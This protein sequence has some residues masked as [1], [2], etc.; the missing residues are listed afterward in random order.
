MTMQVFYRRET[1]RSSFFQHYNP[2]HFEHE[3][4]GGNLVFWVVTRCKMCSK[5]WLRAWKERTKNMPDEKMSLA[6]PR[7]CINQCVNVKMGDDAS[8]GCGQ[9]WRLDNFIRSFQCNTHQ[10]YRQ[11][12]WSGLLATLCKW[13]KKNH[14]GSCRTEI[15]AMTLTLGLP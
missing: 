6:L 8:Q 11:N 1:M 12:C 13:G 2:T 3:C 4:T 5:L 9:Y 10:L 7:H 15:Q 14:L